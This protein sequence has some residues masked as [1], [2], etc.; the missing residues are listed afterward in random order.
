MARLHVAQTVMM[1]AIDMQSLDRW[2]SAPGDWVE[3]P[4]ERRQGESGVRFV[5]IG[6]RQY[7]CKQQSGHLHRSWRHPFGRPTVLRE[8]ESITALQALGVPVPRLVFHAAEK[9]A[10][11]W[12]AIL[13]TEALTGMLPLDRWY[14]EMAESISPDARAMLLTRIGQTLAK[15]HRFGW[16]HS[17]LYAKHVFVRVEDGPFPKAEVVLIDLEKCR[18]R[19]RP[20][21]AAT[22]D[23]NQLHRHRASMSEADWQQLVLNHTQALDG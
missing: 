23:M 9:L 2:W 16:Q 19:L 3:T 6:N 20:A 1:T 14:A 17:C 12:K 10:G 21:Q 8:A 15:M 11:Q 4:N 7:Y 13:V 22:H 5:Q 18:K